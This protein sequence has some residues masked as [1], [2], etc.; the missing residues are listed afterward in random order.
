MNYTTID[1]VCVS[2]K[3][4]IERLLRTIRP[5]F[6]SFLMF[7]CYFTRLKTCEISWQNMR[8]SANVDHI[9]LGTVG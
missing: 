6:S 2:N 9:V 3:Q 5:M 7:C 8:N 1:F 4:V